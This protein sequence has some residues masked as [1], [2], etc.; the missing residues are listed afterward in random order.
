MKS[1]TSQEQ[2]EEVLS[3]SCHRVN[4]KWVFGVQ[5]SWENSQV[6]FKSTSMEEHKYFW[7]L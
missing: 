2:L 3:N 6:G 5:I 1:Y 7:K 4:I